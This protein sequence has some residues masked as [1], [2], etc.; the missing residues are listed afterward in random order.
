MK[1]NENDIYSKNKYL[2]RL[3]DDQRHA[4]FHRTDP[5][6]WI[7]IEGSGPGINWFNIFIWVASAVSFLT[8]IYIINFWGA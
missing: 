2:S 1:I 4:R 5:T 8:I 7:P 6:P 3:C